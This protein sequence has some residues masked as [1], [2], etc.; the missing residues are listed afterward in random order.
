MPAHAG[1]H[2]YNL[3]H[4]GKSWIPACAGMTGGKR[5]VLDPLGCAYQTSAS[6]ANPGWNTRS[7]IAWQ[8]LI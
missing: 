6:A 8:R 1:I 2:D 7:A 3:L 5:Q 4:E